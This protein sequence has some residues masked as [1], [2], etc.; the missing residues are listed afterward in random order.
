[1]KWHIT[2]WPLT[3]LLGLLVLAGCGEDKTT[4]PA[5][6]TDAQGYLDLG[7]S[8]YGAGEYLDAYSSFSQAVDLAEDSSQV[9]AGLSGIGWTATKDVNPASGSPAFEMALQFDSTFTEALGGYAFLLQTIEE[10]Q[11]SNERASALLALDPTWIFEHE[12]DIDYLDVRLLQ[13]ENYYAL[14][15]FQASLEAA[16]ALNQVVGYDPDLG[17]EDFNL[18]TTEGRAQLVLLI[19]ALDDLI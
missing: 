7:W 17:Q 14:A 9:T 18:A 12:N 4:E 10:W 8:Q 5:T 16:L 19:A 3:A 6:P 13:A 11:Q 15:N 2:L 1:M